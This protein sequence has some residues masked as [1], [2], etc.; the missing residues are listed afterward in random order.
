[1]VPDATAEGGGDDGET[2][3]EDGSARKI[4]AGNDRTALAEEKRR[5]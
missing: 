5:T 3:T 1:L 2:T 4:H